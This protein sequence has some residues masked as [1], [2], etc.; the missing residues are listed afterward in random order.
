[1]ECAA[2]ELREVLKEDCYK[3]GNIFGSFLCCSLPLEVQNPL[4]RVVASVLT[5]TSP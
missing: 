4:F 2:F 1:M 3:T 5:T